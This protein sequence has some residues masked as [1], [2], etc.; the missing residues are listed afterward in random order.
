MMTFANPLHAQYLGNS[1]GIGLWKAFETLNRKGLMKTEMKGVFWHN[2]DEALW[3]IREANFL[4]LW[5]LVA[6]VEDLTASKSKTPQ[7]LSDL[8][9]TIFNEHV[10]RQVQEHMRNQPETTRDDLKCQMA[11]FSADIL[12]Y[13]DL[14]DTIH[15]G[16]VGRMED[17]FPLMPCV[18][19]LS[20]E[21]FPRPLS[22]M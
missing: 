16:N 11:M 3:H 10:S 17:L 22:R 14:R 6:E 19:V 15:T 2:L 9:T 18:L 21:L 8:V 13:F 20:R 5:M 4:S 7:E 12:T 1:A